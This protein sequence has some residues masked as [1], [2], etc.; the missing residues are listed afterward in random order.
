MAV[1]AYFLLAVASVVG[2]EWLARNALALTFWKR[3]LH[4]TPAY[5]PPG[6]VTLPRLSIVVAAKDEEENIETCVRSILAQDYPDF[7]LVVVNDRSEDRTAEI[8]EAL[9]ADEPR[10]RT[11]HIDHLPEGWC[12]KNHAMQN[13][14]AL[15]DSP[16][17]L[18]TDADCQFTCPS[19]I[20]LAV[21]HALDQQADM[22]SLLPGLE[23]ESF[24]EMMLQ[25]VCSGVLMIWFRP[26]KV[27]NP[28]K[29]HAYANGMFMLIRREVYQEVGTHE[30]FAGSLIEDMDLARKVKSSGRRLVVAMTAGLVTVRMYTKLAQIVQGWTR[31]FAGVFRRPS[32]LAKALGVLVGRGLT[33]TFL[34][35]IGWLAVGL[36]VA[37]A[38][39]WELLAWVASAGLA[40]ELVMTMRFYHH[41]GGRWWMGLLYPFSCGFVAGLLIRTMLLFAGKGSTITWRGTEYR[42]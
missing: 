2:L 13:G 20:R 17:L 37:P 7:E 6:D 10:V 41:T 38:G 21:S 4:L 29:P 9:A 11:L 36:G 5:Q 27:N 22:L 3:Q 32:G 24:W 31:I 30:A 14:L 26:G 18:M 19:A 1:L 33:L 25:P 35:I 23:M 15:T 42:L 39:P 8:V 40:A 12:G 28:A 16:W 34:T